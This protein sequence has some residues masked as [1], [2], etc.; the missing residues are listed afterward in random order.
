MRN[1]ISLT[2]LTFASVKCSL[3][4]LVP[5]KHKP[6][7]LIFMKSY[8]ETHNIN[9]DTYAIGKKVKIFYMLQFH[10]V[11]C[12]DQKTMRI[13]KIIFAI[14]CQIRTMCA[15][16]LLHQRNISHIFKSI[17]STHNYYT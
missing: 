5:V 14:K 10:V 11:V 9:Y 17:K 13:L 2:Y 1:I 6:D 8:L 15:R 4:N 12:K 3:Q 7:L 16:A